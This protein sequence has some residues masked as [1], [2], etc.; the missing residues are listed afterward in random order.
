MR[1]SKPASTAK[2]CTSTHRYASRSFPGRCACAWRPNTR[3]THRLQSPK[4]QYLG[5]VSASASFCR[6]VS[7]R[8]DVHIAFSDD[9]IPDPLPHHVA[10]SVFR[11]LQEAVTNAADIKKRVDQLKKDGKKSVLLLVSNPEGELRF[12]ALSVQ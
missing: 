9:G 2:P 3:A 7:T 6:E 12:V 1:R 4:L 11:V 8:Q 5:V 10:L